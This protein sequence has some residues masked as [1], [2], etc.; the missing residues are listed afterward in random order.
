MY[1]ND[2]NMDGNQSD[3]F[4]SELLSRFE[5]MMNNQQSSFFDADELTEL[6]DYYIMTSQ[7][8]FAKSALDLG[9]SQF[10]DNIDMLVYQCRYF[11]AAGRSAKAIE[12]LKEILKSQ[13]EN[14][15]ALITIGEILSDLGKQSDAVD[16]LEIALKFVEHDER[17]LVMQQIVDALDDAGQHYKM[18]PYLKELIHFH[19]GNSEA[20]S[21]LAFC[22]N[23][24]NR[25]EEGIIFFMKLIDNDPFNAYAWFNLGTLYFG[26]G[27]FEKAVECFEYVL[28]IEPKFTTAAIKMGSAL[29]ALDRIDSAIKVY[30]SVLEYE[31]KDASIHCYI[32]NC[33]SQKKDYKNAIHHFHKSISLDADMTDAHLGLAYAYAGADMFIPS[34]KHII[35]VIEDYDDV[36]DLWFFRAYLEEQ[37]DKYQEAV[38]SFRKG[39]DL[40]P[41]DVNAWLS[42]AGMLTEYFSDFTEALSVLDDAIEHN[43]DNV[44]VYYRAAAV[45][46][47]TGLDSEGSNR[48]HHAL[49][50]DK[51]QYELL[52]LYNPLLQNNQKIIDILNHY[53]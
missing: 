26:T 12:M 21:S 42:L 31:K 52:F 23:I 2:F 48:L 37:L 27:L 41:S 44:E 46:F 8:Q 30:K 24:L 1:N 40:N 19:S 13:P 9:L 20:M 50:L 51:S 28:A 49:S 47:E 43:S 45:C 10:P 36:A 25:E 11:H 33:Y 53:L 22:Y 29:A 38:D 18:I 39:L 32:A 5:Q 16:Y 35:R 15:E 6:I 3:D 17:Q 14:I 7:L 4:L 34:Y